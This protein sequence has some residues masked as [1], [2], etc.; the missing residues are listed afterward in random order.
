MSMLAALARKWHYSVG[1]PGVGRLVYREGNREYTFPLYEEN[2]ELVIAA[3]PSSQRIHFFFNW[4]GHPQEFSAAAR[5]RILPRI[6]KHLHETGERV[7]IFE[8]CGQSEGEFEFYPELFEHRARASELLAAAGYDWF[9]DYSSIDVLHGEYGLEIC[10]IPQERDA[11]I[12][13]EIL[14]E[15]FP[16]WHHQNLCLNEQGR[17][18]GWTVALGMF[19]A[20]N[21]SADWHDGD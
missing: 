11:R 19:P 7:R 1:N 8:R 5:E 2:G 20:R 4:Y 21:E 15:G 9:S 3:V 17:E 16:H 10:G 6:Q 13:A 12:I 18:P 14:G